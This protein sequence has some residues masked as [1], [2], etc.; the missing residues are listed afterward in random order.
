MRFAARCALAGLAGLTL[1]G[2]T[3]GPQ[4][5]RPQATVPAGFKEAGLLKAAV[6]AD[7]L[8]KG[9]WWTVF[10]DPELNALQ[11]QAQRNSPRLQ[12]AAARVDQARALAGVVDANAWPTLELVPIASRYRVSG[13]RPD[14][15]SKVPGNTEYT[16]DRF[17]LPLYASYEVD[18]WGK[19]RRQRE[20]ASAR[21]EA[22]QA[23]YGTV[24]LTLQAEIAQTYF[25]LRA[26][27]EDLRILVNNLELRR[28][29]LDLV[30]A[31]IR[32]GL[33]TEFDLARLEAEVATTQGEL[34]A[35]ARRSVELQ[36]A[37]AVLVG[38]TPESFALTEQP[39]SPASAPPEIPVG[40]PSDLLERRPDVAEAERLLIARNAEIGV[41]ETAFFPSIKLT[42][43]AGFESAELSDLLDGDSAI[44][45]LAGS[46]TQPL[47]DGGRNRANLERAQAVWREN[48]ALYRDRLLV[49]F[50]E[51]DDALAGLRY[52]EAQHAALSRA[53][54]SAEKAERLATSRYRSGL[55][56][57][58]DVID[59][60]RVRLQTERQR[61]QTTT[62]R[63][64][65]SVALVRALGGGWSDVPS[66]PGNPERAPAASAT[67]VPQHKE[68]SG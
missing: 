46:L 5:A 21:V 58:L 1:A 27:R 4:Y 16:T 22:S 11:E 32:S 41:A 48:V 60:Q 61:L 64:L 9:A 45:A 36:Y 40:L 25:A 44:W 28:K 42:G 23:A 13:N 7:Q 15:P 8:P 67:P 47:F 3:L 2:C 55:S 31:R 24:L 18:L 56:L 14:Q 33:A 37:L 51:V 54:A 53:V 19:L 63:M 68:V 30:A 29:A 6:P 17:V 65:V 57:V 20:S 38:E 35:A 12:A 62:Q 49:A 39:L 26:A 59:A 52:L 34:E 50:R 66:D 10:A 43:A